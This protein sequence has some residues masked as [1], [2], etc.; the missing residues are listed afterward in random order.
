[1]IGGETMGTLEST[2]FPDG[3]PAT[4]TMSDLG[5]LIGVSPAQA[6]KILDVRPDMEVRIP[7][8]KT[9]RV[10][11]DLYFEIVSKNK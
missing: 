7:G 3:I 8:T 5:R 2:L 11:S 4:I 9:R 1:M 10:N 6:G